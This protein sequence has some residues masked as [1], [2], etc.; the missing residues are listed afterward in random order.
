MSL[1]RLLWP[2]PDRAADEIGCLGRL[3][4]VF[5]WFCAGIAGL[6]AI[7]GVG[8]AISVMLGSQRDD[9]WGWALACIF[10]GLAALVV[11]RAMRFILAAE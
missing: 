7:A 4:R 2:E 3:G 11:G 10:F 5:H 8:N 9:G 6:F 1:R